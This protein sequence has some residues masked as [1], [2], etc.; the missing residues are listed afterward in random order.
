MMSDRERWIVYPLLFMT[1]GLSLRDRIA[2]ES[3][4]KLSI[5]EVVCN[6]LEVVSS[7]GRPQIRLSV[8][9][10]GG[11]IE[12]RRL[13]GRSNI[14]D[15]PAENDVQPADERDQDDNVIT[16]DSENGSTSPSAATDG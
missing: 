10:S 13:P 8:T 14:E 7:D 12:V 16:D 9:T 11:V 3:V 1:L 5:D 4:Q 2:G 6:Q 15:F